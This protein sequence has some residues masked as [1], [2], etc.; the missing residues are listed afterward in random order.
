MAMTIKPIFTLKEAL[1]GLWRNRLMS[2]A[3]V[4]SVAATLIILGVIFALVVNINAISNSAKDQ[5]DTIQIYIKE[6]VTTEGVQGLVKSIEAI[7]GVESTLFESKSDA[8]EKMKLSWK[9]NAY[10]LEGL[11]ENPLPSSIIVSLKD[12]YY[13]ESVLKSIEGLNGIEDIKS[14]Q[15]VVDKLLKITEL[16]RKSGMIIIF[17]LIAIST[18]IIHNTIK[19]AVNTRQ[20]EI[21][22]M[23]YV[24]ATNWFIRWPF[25]V[26]G[27][28]LGLIGAALSVGV[29]RFFYEYVYNLFTSE[30]YALASTYF[31]VP[32]A[33]IKDTVFLFVIIGVGIGSLGSIWSMRKHLK[34]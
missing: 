24:G 28:I 34:V 12:I 7:K 8:L 10:L 21:T 16:I 13:A 33:L 14:Y 11:E 25:L 27:M 5:F 32:S 4:T 15:K 22:I 19:L 9:D 2:I 29:I 17:V 3:S 20:K 31:I 23:K 26:E 30:F 18:F 6:D 1:K